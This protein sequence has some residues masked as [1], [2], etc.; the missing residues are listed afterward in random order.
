MSHHAK[1][2]H[3][4]LVSKDPTATQKFLEKAFGMKFTEMG[5]EMG[6]YRMH[7]R[8]EQTVAG[9]IGIREPM[10][11]E[12]PGTVSYFTVPNID[13]AI[14]NVKAAGGKMIMEKTEIPKMGFTAMYHAPGGVVLGVFQPAAP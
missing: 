12:P 5:P 11:P 3:A 10:G 13:E 1:M 14:K 8:Q 7:G 4:E 2:D 9:S 6:N